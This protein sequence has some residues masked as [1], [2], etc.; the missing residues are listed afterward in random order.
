MIG[1]LAA[2]GDVS[3][4]DSAPGAQSNAGAAGWTGSVLA[5]WRKSFGKAEP[6]RLSDLVIFPVAISAT[7]GLIKGISMAAHQHFLDPALVGYSTAID[8]VIQVAI[9]LLSITLA[10]VTRCRIWSG[11]LFAIGIFCFL[12]IP[13]FLHIFLPGAGYRLD[14]LIA[15]LGAFQIAATVNRYLHTRLALWMIGVPALVALCALAYGGAREYSLRNALPPPPNSP[16]V[17]LI[18]VDTLRADHVSPYGYTR[19][20]TPYLS[21]MAQQ[22][23][24]FENAIAPS[25]W[26]LPSHASMLTGLYPHQDRVQTENDSLSRILPTLGEAM[27]KRG[28]RTAAFSANNMYFSRDH[29]LARGF[30]HFENYEQTFA[31]ILEKVP[32]SALILGKLSQLTSGGTGAFFGEKNA[33]TAERIDENAVDW[34]ERGQRPFFVMLNYFDVHEPVLPP[35]PYLHM[36]TTNPEAR[37][38]NMHFEQNCIDRDEASCTADRQQFVDVYD[39]ATRYVDGNIQHLLSQLKERGLL[40]NTI[41]VVTADHGQEFGDHGLFGHHESLYRGEIQVPLIFWKPGLIPAS[42][43]VATPVSTSDLPATI[44]QMTGP[45]AAQPLPGHSLAPLWLSSPPV[46]TWPEPISELAK[47]HWFNKSATNYDHPIRSIVTP[48]WHYI[49]QEDQELLFDW[50]TDPEEARDQC[51]AQPSVCATLKAKLEAA[52]ARQPV[53]H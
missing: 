2:T 17:L 45:D 4:S 25:S 35:K 9:L 38:Q 12:A 33:A 20:T 41:V 32:L 47:L 44:L 21:Q 15:V 52:S 43:R 39:G 16:N 8:I 7:A 6:T 40:E 3:L 53:A 42:V 49:Q 14:L 1:S 26:T 29:G 11:T 51:A 24:L 18:I 36:Y 50:K 37:N 28:Y 13:G 27:N 48:E 31:G 23:V 5:F 22:G 34:I 19:D 30:M 46:S 10:F